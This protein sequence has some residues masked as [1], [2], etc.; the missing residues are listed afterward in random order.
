MA[1]QEKQASAE[2]LKFYLGAGAKILQELGYSYLPGDHNP[3]W[4]ALAGLAPLSEEEIQELVDAGEMTEAEAAMILEAQE[5]GAGQ[6][7]KL[8]PLVWKG[9]T[10]QKSAILRAHILA[11]TVV[12]NNVAGPIGTGDLAAIR[13]R[14]YFSK[15]ERALGFKFAAQ[16][17]ETY[18]VRSADVVLVHDD[19]SRARAFKRGAKRVEFKVNWTKSDAEVLEEELGRTPRIHIWPK[20]EWGR[21]YAMQF[22][23]L[24]GDL[25]REGLTYE[26]L[27]IRDASRD[28]AKYSPLTP[29]FYG[30][31]ILEKGSLFEH[32]E[33][34]CK[35]AG[36]PILLA[37]SGN[38]A[39]SSVESI[40]NDH[41]RHWDGRYKPTAENPLHLFCI[42]DHDYAGMIPVQEGAASQFK[43]YLPDAVKVHRVGVTPQQLKDLGRSIVFVGYEFE[44]DYNTAYSDWAD[45]HG[46]WIGD[47]CYGIEVE[48]LT[49]AEY[50][51]YLI[52][53][54]VEA[55]G[56][57]DEVREKLAKMAE[58]NWYDIR[59]K[60]EDEILDMSTLFRYLKTLAQW[61][62]D[63]TTSEAEE[64]VTDW[65]QHVLGDEQDEDAWR[66][67]PDLM[68]KV[69]EQIAEQAEGIDREAFTEHVT[70]KGWGA[71]RPADSSQA[72][73]VVA[74]EFRG[75][76]EDDMG[77]VADA[78]DG[79][80]DG[81]MRDYL[82]DADTYTA[83]EIA[84]DFAGDGELLCALRRVFDLLSEHDL[85]RPQSDE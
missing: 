30:A 34:F 46:I 49:P 26:E 55:L 13:Q 4:E 76:F 14:W 73:E 57:D 20:K 74:D 2:D 68:K 54:I 5:R 7:E 47:T 27:W 17:L 48:V 44:A 64:P 70:G 72:N 56:G 85:E 83:E 33:D 62:D 42:S 12:L 10:P 21:A 3:V 40:L 28:V 43:R 63:K 78:V 84:A 22:S 39:F 61:C 71:W 41:F 58:P 1:R 8:R 66:N 53:A 59:R 9:R 82:T 18:L 60:L 32:F 35:A 15:H 77:H 52:D 45:E 75:E 79:G 6:A 65:V 25:V 29:D 80:I 69:A 16:A 23:Q 19:R 81:Q 31:L 51:P 11:Q 67:Q 24:L 38:N 37:M 36:V 50:M